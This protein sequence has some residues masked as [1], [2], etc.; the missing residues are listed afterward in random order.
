MCSVTEDLYVFI[1]LMTTNCLFLVKYVNDRKKLCM[2]TCGFS[3][4]LV[5]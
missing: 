5:I 3:I 1:Q 4:Y 2:T